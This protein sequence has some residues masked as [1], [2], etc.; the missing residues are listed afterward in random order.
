MDTSPRQSIQACAVLCH[1]KGRCRR[2][3]SNCSEHNSPNHQP[4]H[5]FS[6]SAP[7]QKIMNFS[8]S[9]SSLSQHPGKKAKSD[10]WEELGKVVPK[11]EA[12]NRMMIFYRKFMKIRE[13]Y[14]ARNVTL[15][16][17]QRMSGLADDLENYVLNNFEVPLLHLPFPWHNTAN[18]WIL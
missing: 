6:A 18:A 2:G 9:I 8:A 10:V 5:S 12:K 13:S 17:R 15:E 14:K 16:Q 4:A 1:G 11:C 3:I 7:V